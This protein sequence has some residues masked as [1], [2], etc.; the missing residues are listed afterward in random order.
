MALAVFLRGVNV[1]GHKTFRPA[2]LAKQLQHLG[3]ENIGA[4]GTFVFRKRV[5]RTKLTAELKRRL[6]FETHIIVCDGRD[7]AALVARDP[8]RGEPARPDMVRF[9][10]V[11]S[12]RPRKEPALPFRLPAEGDWLLKITGREGRFV[13]GLYRRNM[14][15]IGNLGRLD[16]LFGVP[17]TTRNWNTMAAVAKALGT[18]DN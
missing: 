14:K 17:A 16:K 3:A 10:S 5:A 13:F 9:V 8:F 1:G 7:V 4:A 6:P 18:A 15:A 2:L 11:L 12:Q